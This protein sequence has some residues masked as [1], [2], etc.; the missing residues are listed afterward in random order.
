VLVETALPG[1]RMTLA[2]T[3][4]EFRSGKVRLL[5]IHWWGIECRWGRWGG[6]SN[7]SPGL[8]G[9]EN[10]LLGWVLYVDDTIGLSEY[11][12]F[13]FLFLL[14]LLSS[15]KGVRRRG[16]SRGFPRAID[17]GSVSGGSIGIPGGLDSGR[18]LVNSV[19]NIQRGDWERCPKV[20]R[21]R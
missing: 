4:T 9:S 15:G 13:G 11:L 5:Q 19:Y 2:L 16:A 3:G 8:D 17:W 1:D 10:W 18:P 20:G 12:G 6:R 7:G 21:R 14:F